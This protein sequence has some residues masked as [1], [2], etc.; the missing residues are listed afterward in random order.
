MHD[1]IVC[2]TRL[3]ECGSDRVQLANVPCHEPCK[4]PS[5]A[6]SPTWRE[7]GHQHENLRTTCHRVPVT[8]DGLGAARTAHTVAS[9]IRRR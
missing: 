1:N 2:A 3:A 8:A 7:G 9:L 6:A 5:R 4:A